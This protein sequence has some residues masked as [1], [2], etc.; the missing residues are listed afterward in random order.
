MNTPDY[1]KDYYSVEHLDREMSSDSQIRR[2]KKV[3]EHCVGSVLDVGAGVGKLGEELKNKGHVFELVDI[4]DDY[5]KH[6]TSKGLN[7][8]KGNAYS[9]KYDDSSFD[10]VTLTDGVEHF[11]NFGKVLSECCRIARKKVVLTI[12]KDS[13]DT[14]WHLWNITWEPTDHWLVVEFHRNNEKGERL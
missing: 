7:A 4:N 13:K 5:V 14:P 12:C 10:T 9:L 6:M 2:I 11:E 3:A 1:E 8:V